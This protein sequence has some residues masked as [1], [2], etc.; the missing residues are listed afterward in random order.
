MNAGAMGGWIFD[1]VESVEW[2]GPDG[3]IRAAGRAAFDAGYRDCPQLH[4]AIVLSAVLR[5]E[6]A[7]DPSAIRARMDVMSASRRASQP[8]DP[9]A[10]C[11]F[12]NPPADKAGRL[13]EQSGLKGESVGGAQVS[14][15]HANFIVNTGQT[16][17]TEVLTLLRRVRGVVKAERGIELEPEILVLGK[18]WRDLL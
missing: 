17:A 8:R 13:I 12:R 2:L 11:I 9:S 3:R 4:G 6:R 10:G 5:A 1:R 18:E 7:D 16:T 14:P 15:V